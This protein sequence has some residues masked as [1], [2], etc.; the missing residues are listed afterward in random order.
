MAEKVEME[1]KEIAAQGSVSGVEPYELPDGWKW[2][3]VGS[4]AEIING[5]SQKEVEDDNGL[6]PIYGSGGIIGRAR[7][8]ICPENCTIIGRK[9]TINNPI[10]VE[11]KFWNAFQFFNTRQQYSYSKFDKN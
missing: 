9:G 2:T 3:D 1:A 11:T 7:D 6:Y 8:F 4:I 5:K 10:F